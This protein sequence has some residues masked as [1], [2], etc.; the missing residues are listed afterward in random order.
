MLATF[1]IGL[2]LLGTQAA[3]TVALPDTPQGK[4]VEAFIKAFN[5]G[6]EKTF[7]RAEEEHLTKTMLDK[8]PVADRGQMFKRMQG[9]FGTFT[10][11][12]VVKSTPQ[13]TQIILP[14]R[15]G[16]DAL[17]TFDF[18]QDAPFRIVGIGVDRSGR[19]RGDEMSQ[20]VVVA[21]AERY[22]AIVRVR[23]SSNGTVGA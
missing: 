9:D 10:V 18:E 5:T 17:F 3:K 21:C 23:P 8:R 20:T 2:T 7:L 15:Q 13:Q 4:H 12:K 1:L 6:D 19:P 14:T 16:E 22:H 11:Q